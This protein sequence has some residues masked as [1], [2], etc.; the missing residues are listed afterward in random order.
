[1][2]IQSVCYLDESP[3][4]QGMLVSLSGCLFVT[5]M[6]LRFSRYVGL[7]VR[8][9]VCPFVCLS[10]CLSVDPLQVAIVHKIYSN[11]ICQFLRII[12]RHESKKLRKK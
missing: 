8:M 9:S 4:L 6:N 10:V 3:I 5:L 1:M 11:A 2:C 12:D 7:F